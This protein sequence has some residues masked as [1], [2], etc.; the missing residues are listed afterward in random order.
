M[1]D[2]LA[3]IISLLSVIVSVIMAVV[4]TDNYI[5]KRSIDFSKW[6]FEYVSKPH[7][8]D[9]INGIVKTKNSACK[10][11]DL[12]FNHKDD[13]GDF[14]SNLDFIILVFYRS[15][16]IKK[17]MREQIL[18]PIFTNPFLCQC[19]DFESQNGY[20]LNLKKEMIRSKKCHASK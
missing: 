10:F 18:Y 8:L 15:R 6:F 9:L 19:I 5:T 2:L 11:K 17:L 14:L 4:T 12:M 13:F 3:L 1:N 7:F 16:R 20:Y